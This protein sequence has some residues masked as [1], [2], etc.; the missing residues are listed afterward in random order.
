[1]LAHF[2]D[3][4]FLLEF[5]GVLLPSPEFNSFCSGL[6]QVKWSFNRPL[7]QGV[8]SNLTRLLV[9]FWSL[10]VMLP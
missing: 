1:V 2:N 10:R 7:D 5:L 4:G 8:S 6:D 9:Y 3:L